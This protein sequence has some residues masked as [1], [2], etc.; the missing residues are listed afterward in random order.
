MYL[1]KAVLELIPVIQIMFRNSGHSQDGIHGG[2][3]IMAH[4]GQ[5]FGF[6]LVGPVSSCI[7]LLKGLFG[8]LFLFPVLQFLL[9]LR[10]DVADCNNNGLGTA[11]LHRHQVDLQPVPG[12]PVLLSG[13]TELGLHMFIFLGDFLKQPVPGAHVPHPLPVSLVRL[14]QDIPIQA[15]RKPPCPGQW[16]LPAGIR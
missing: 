2:T 3:D 7:G 11:L 10:T 16:F 12:S 9:F 13:Q 8:L 5:E 4:P 6:G 14:F 1:Q 15:F